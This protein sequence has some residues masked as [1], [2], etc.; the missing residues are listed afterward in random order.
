MSTPC[1]ALAYHLT[2][3]FPPKEIT[4]RIVSSV[5]YFL[6]L[7]SITLRASCARHSTHTNT[8]PRILP[9]L[10]K[11]HIPPTPTI[12]KLTLLASY[13]SHPTVLPLYD[14]TYT[15]RHFAFTTT[16]AI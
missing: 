3:N 1:T 5:Q 7:L 11:P 4:H 10:R 13:Q 15:L 6:T 2:Y 8:K 14:T 16:L 9:T 12:L